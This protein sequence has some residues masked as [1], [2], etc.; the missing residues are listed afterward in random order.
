MAAALRAHSGSMTSIR[1]TRRVVKR[2]IQKMANTA[3]AL[4]AATCAPLPALSNE[5]MPACENAG[6]S[7]RTQAVFHPAFGGVCR[8]MVDPDRCQSHARSLE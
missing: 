5:T 1:K 6:R 8:T 2:T 4:S 3:I 7:E